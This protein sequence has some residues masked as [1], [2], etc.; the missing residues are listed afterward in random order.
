VPK[1]VQDVQTRVQDLKELRD[2]SSVFPTYLKNY[3]FTVEPL[4]NAFEK[5]VETVPSHMLF[6]NVFLQARSDFMLALTE[7]DNEISKSIT[8]HFSKCKSPRELL[9]VYLGYTPLLGFR[10]P[11]GALFKDRQTE[12]LTWVGKSLDIFQEKGILSFG[13]LFNRNFE[14]LSE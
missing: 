4:Q 7:I 2:K 14:L 1:G 10:P 8:S 13:C 3:G 6:D 12:L 5:V 11:L 9:E